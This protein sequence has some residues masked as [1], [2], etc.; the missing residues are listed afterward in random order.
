MY[1]RTDMGGAMSELKGIVAEDEPVLRA[2][3]RS[4]LAD[5][6]PELVVCAE[7]EDGLQ[8]L[9]ALNEHAP[10]VLFLDI[11]MPGL[12]GLEVAKQ[13]SGKCHVVFVT[14]FDSYAVAAFEQGAVDYVL[15]PFSPAR[16]ATAVSRLREKVRS[17]PANL[18]GLLEGLHAAATRGKKY[19]RWLTVSE[20]EDL[21]L[22]TVDEI[23]YFRADNKYTVVVT[24]QQES[25]VRRSIKELIDELD[26]KIFLQIHRGTLVNANAIA[27][28][29]RDFGGRL[30]VKLK[31][32]K[33]KLPV[34]DPY[35]HLF[36]RM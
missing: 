9:R 34:S 19:M 8:A 25:L 28:V 13:A 1:T 27:G 20:R 29:T 15:K 5:L 11:E 22:I 30:W 6:W 16:L 12:S 35:I 18:D 33:E 26:P 7:A 21:R 14:A 4:A 23:C 2:K 24:P 10:A 3:L 36:N 17:V 31:Q 32:R